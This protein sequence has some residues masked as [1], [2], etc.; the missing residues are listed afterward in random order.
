MVLVYNIKKKKKKKNGHE[1]NYFP[2][3][4][5][6]SLTSVVKADEWNTP[7]FKGIFSDSNN[8]FLWHESE[9]INKKKLISKISVD[10]NFAFWSYAWLC[11][12]H[13]SH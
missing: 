7:L 13:C 9:D 8:I 5:G 11:V 6:N 2:K 4:E 10:S 1:P 3:G 12:F